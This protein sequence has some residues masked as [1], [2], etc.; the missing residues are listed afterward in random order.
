[1]DSSLCRTFQSIAFRTFDLL[2]TARAV[3]HQPGEETITDLNIIELKARNRRGIHSKAFGKNVEGRNGADWEWWIT[4]GPM[5]SWLG[6]RVQAK[7][8]NLVSGNFEHLHYQS[9][10]PPEYQ[11]VKLK[12]ASRKAGLIPL[13]CYYLHSHSLEK[14][15]SSICGTYPFTLESYGCSLSTLGHVERLF[16]AGKKNDLASVIQKA[17]PWHCLVCCSGYGGDD[18]PGRAWAHLK[19]SLEVNESSDEHEQGD[20][21][22]MLVGPRQAPPR[23]VIEAMEDIESESAP[24]DIGGV[25]IIKSSDGG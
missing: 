10:N 8:L 20:D 24:A 17:Y 22:Q 21:V 18:L 6:L 3:N 13:Y 11:R 14:S 19:G 15:T 5:N 16:K 2:G 12:R 7:I 25:L 4:N 9:G 1:M 23:Y